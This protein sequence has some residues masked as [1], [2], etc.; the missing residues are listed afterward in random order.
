MTRNPSTRHNIN[1]TGKGTPDNSK[2][3]QPLQA[4]KQKIVTLYSPSWSA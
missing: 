1:K 4:Q 3:L 2:N